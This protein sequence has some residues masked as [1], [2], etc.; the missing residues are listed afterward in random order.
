M[1]MKNTFLAAVMVVGAIT[2]T[3]CGGGDKAMTE[4]EHA[5]SLGLSEEEYQ[6]NKEAAARMN[7]DVDEHVKMGH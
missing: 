4:A 7:M 1:R 3:G 2:L 5:A 6:E